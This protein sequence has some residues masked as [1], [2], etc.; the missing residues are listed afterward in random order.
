MRMS[1]IHVVNKKYH[2]PS[3]QDIYIGRGS[4]LGNPYTSLPLAKTKAMYQCKTKEEAV[5]KYRIWLDKAVRSKDSDVQKKLL[6]IYNKAK[7]GNVNLVCYCAPNACHGDVIKEKIEKMISYSQ[8]K[9]NKVGPIQSMEEIIN[10]SGGAIGSDSYW[11]SIGRKFGVKNHVHYYPKGN[12]NFRGNKP[13][14]KNELLLADQYL[15]R[16]N[17]ILK[18]RFPAENEYVNN[19]LRR[20]YY[21]VKN[22][23]MVVA[24]GTINNDR[25]EGGT[26]W[27]VHMAPLLNKR[28]FVFDQIKNE[29]YKLSKGGFRRCDVP[30]L[31]RNFAG[32]GTR[33]I[34]AF[35][36]KAIY[37][38]YS[39][40]KQKIIERERNRN[41]QMAQEFDLGRE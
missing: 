2:S 14:R 16:V 37:N 7:K 38:V 3:D 40:T 31:T 6:E 34:N 4:G 15:N 11:D 8:D 24:V 32:I 27:A 5:E 35:G 36:K 9:S 22:A 39:K 21:Q 33:E 26:G 25:V 23:D 30:E 1:K 17:E 18:R 19:L 29:W 12:K 10:H 13:L 41:K 20:N 28:A